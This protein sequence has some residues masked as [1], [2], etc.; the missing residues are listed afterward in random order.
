VRRLLAL[1]VT[2]ALA[3]VALPACKEVAEKSTSGYEPSKLESVKGTDVK[4]VTFTAE[5]AR[6][7]GLRTAPVRRTGSS[8]V[9]VPY[10][11]LIYDAAGKT[12]VYT[13]P[14][15]LSYRREEVKVD[16]IDGE[17]ALLSE[18]PRV[19]TAVVTVGVFEAYGTE[20]E[21]ASK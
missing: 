14:K 11:A 6:R 19:G 1:G 15:P 17:R 10:A 2:L 4:R 3:A 7:A 13:S 16:R 20:L 12:Y 8:K 9:V 21:I 5:G 18:G